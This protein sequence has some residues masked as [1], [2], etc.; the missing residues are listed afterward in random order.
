MFILTSND[1]RS[2]HSRG[3]AHTRESTFTPR[4]LSKK[5][6]SARPPRTDL[7]DGVQAG[8]SAWPRRS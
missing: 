5:Q 8:G 6:T 1:F 4:A 7:T 3:E 2:G